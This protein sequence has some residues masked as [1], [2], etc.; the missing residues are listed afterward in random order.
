[1]RGG[2]KAGTGGVNVCRTQLCRIHTFPSPGLQAP[3]LSSSMRREA[4]YS[5][6]I[7]GRIDGLEP[8]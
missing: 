1:M 5:V 3:L 4:G 8:V 2:R 6:R 7:V